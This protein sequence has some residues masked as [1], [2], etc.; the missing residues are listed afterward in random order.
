MTTSFARIRRVCL[1]A[2]AFAATGCSALGIDGGTTE[3]S[4]LGANRAKWAQRELAAYRFT[5]QRSCFCDGT[6]PLAIEV[7]D[8][9]VV[10]ATF[11]S[12]NEPLPFYLEAHLPTVDS[13]F[14]AVDRAIAQRVD[15]LEVDYHPLLGYPTRIA[16][17]YAFNMAD[18]EIVHQASGLTPSPHD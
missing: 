8:R 18:D 10:S 11:E 3:R 9:M 1:V 2:L 13:L 14:A 4:R 16:I 7:V 17:D 6:A 5:Y 12:S 15:L